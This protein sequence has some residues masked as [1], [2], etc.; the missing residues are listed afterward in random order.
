MIQIPDC[1]RRRLVLW[2]VRFMNRR[3]ADVVIEKDYLSRWWLIKTRW[4]R[5]YLHCAHRSDRDRALHDHPWHN[6]SLILG[7]EYV[8]ML[9]DGMRCLAPGA[10]VFRRAAFCHRL[11]I[12]RG[13]VIS[14]F[15]T[16]PK[17]REWGFWP[18]AGP[19]A[20]RNWVHW[21]QFVKPG[22]YSVAEKA[23]E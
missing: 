3:P 4:L 14:L 19:K 20:G 9:W 1:I 6:A 7:G 23:A 22:N 21:K 10:L 12:V 5:V 11:V 17:I 8:E 13:P 2:A 16:G 15:I 18:Y